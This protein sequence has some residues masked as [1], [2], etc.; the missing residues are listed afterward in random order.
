MMA[1]YMRN[2]TSDVGLVVG[3]PIA[4]RPVTIAGHIEAFL[5]NGHA[6]LLLTASALGIGFGV[7]K[8]M[9]FRRSDLARAG[10]IEAMAYTIAEDTAISKGLAAIGLKTVFAHRTL[11]QVVGWRSLREIYD[12]QL[13]WSV[14]RRSHEPLTFPLEP[15]ATPLPAAIAAIF[16]APLLGVS[17]ATAFA[18]TAVGWFGC[19]ILVARI[20]GW[21]VS[22][23]SPLAFIGRELLTLATWLR[24]WTTDDVVWAN[25]RFEVLNAAPVSRDGVEAKKA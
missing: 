23:F 5:I 12:R 2:F 11:R 7:G 13:R 4:E 10:G 22:W 18:L 20:K 19:E 1:A 21:E 25:G 17:A 3:V 6:R 8:A 24:A 14:I 9:L 16:A 15:I